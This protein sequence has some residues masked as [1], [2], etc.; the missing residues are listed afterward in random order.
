MKSGHRRAVTLVGCLVLF[1]GVA[2]AQDR[3]AEVPDDP[4]TLHAPTS[5]ALL[6]DAPADAT[7][8]APPHMSDPRDQADDDWHFQLTFSL[9]LT[10]A[11]GSQEVRDLKFDY[12]ICFS[13]LIQ[14]ANYAFNPGAELS[15]GN[16]SLLYYMTYAKISADRTGALGVET[17]AQNTIGAFD[18]LVGYSIVRQ[19]YPDG[20]SLVVMPAIGGQQTYFDGKLKVGSFPS[21]SQ[22]VT[23]FDPIVAGRVAWEFVPHVTWRNEG[24]IGGFGVGSELTWSVATYLDWQCN[25][26]ITLSLGYRALSWDYDLGPG[27]T[28]LTLYGPWIGLTWQLF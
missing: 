12:D 21:R 24:M 28:R 10:S 4:W 15:K 22:T 7:A 27:D 5:Y 13:E 17:N 26:S 14:N 19:R 16:W 1:A 18:L 25:R 9:W 23:F 11:Q 3:T 20:T 8:D 6:A 2:R